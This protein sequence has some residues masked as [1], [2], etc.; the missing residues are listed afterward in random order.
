M[1]ISEAQRRAVDKY[2]KA[3]Y[4]RIELKVIKGKKEEIKAHADHKGE[5][6]NAFI[7]RAIIEQMK[8]DQ[9]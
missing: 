8:R 7:N 3:N 5:S 4:D 9:E 6:I 2:N 1:A